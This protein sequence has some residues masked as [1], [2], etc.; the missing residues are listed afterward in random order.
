MK[1]DSNNKRILYIT[2][3]GILQPLGKSQI[4]PYLEK[5][6][7]NYLID[8]LSFERNKDL[9]QSKIHFNKNI[10]HMKINFTKNN[11]INSLL[12]IYTFIY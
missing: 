12:F 2:F 10:K 1:E 3:D 5:L 9:S 8:I 11:I 6:S 4:L 7:K